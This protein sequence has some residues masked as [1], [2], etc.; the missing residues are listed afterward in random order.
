MEMGIVKHEELATA[1]LRAWGHV[2]ALDF[3]VSMALGL[4]QDKVRLIK[5]WDEALPDRIDEWMERSEYQNQDFRDELH[6]TLAHLRELLGA[7]AR[8]DHG[9]DDD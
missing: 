4:H 2:W 8:V 9:D 7:A 6:G 5:I 3:A 1:L